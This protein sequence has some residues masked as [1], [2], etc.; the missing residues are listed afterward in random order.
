[1]GEL[2]FIGDIPYL[3][4]FFAVLVASCKFTVKT[5]NSYWPIVLA[6]RYLSKLPENHSRTA[7]KQ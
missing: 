5:L 2:T 3:L 7:E 1:M 6:P 4:N